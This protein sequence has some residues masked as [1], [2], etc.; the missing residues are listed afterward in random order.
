MNFILFRVSHN[1]YDVFFGK[2]WEDWARVV[3]KKATKQLLCIKGRKLTDA[4]ATA[5]Q[6]A[7]VKG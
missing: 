4:E 6:T 2:G 5:I 3:Y 1:V 7:I